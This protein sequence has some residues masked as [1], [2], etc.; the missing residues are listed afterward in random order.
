MN[1][2]NRNI[3]SYPFSVLPFHH[4]EIFPW[5]SMNMC[6]IFIVKYITSILK[7]LCHVFK[8]QTGF[9]ALY[10]LKEK[11]SETSEM[12]PVT[13]NISIAIM[14]PISKGRTRNRKECKTTL[15]PTITEN[16]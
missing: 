1:S 12:I 9:V 15:L 7:L 4:L 10:T 11:G 5:S 3:P 2:P 14:F 8:E 6:F 13:F 16:L